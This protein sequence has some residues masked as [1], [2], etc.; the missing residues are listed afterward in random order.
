[1]AVVI[2]ADDDDDADAD[3]RANTADADAA[4]ANAPAKL[5][6]TGW[7]GMFVSFYWFSAPSF[8]VSNYLTLCFPLAAVSVTR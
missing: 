4:A 6:G 1:M 8:H 2:H 5:G 3:E 7:A